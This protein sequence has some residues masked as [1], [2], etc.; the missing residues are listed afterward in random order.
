MKT[1]DTCVV[2]RQKLTLHQSASFVS[3]TGCIFTKKSPRAMNGTIQD[4]EL[5]GAMWCSAHSIKCNERDISR[6][7]SPAS[8]KHGSFHLSELKHTKKPKQEHHRQGSVIPLWDKHLWKGCF[9]KCCGER[10]FVKC[11]QHKTCVELSCQYQAFILRE[12]IWTESTCKI[13]SID[14]TCGWQLISWTGNVKCG[15]NACRSRCQVAPKPCVPIYW[16]VSNLKSQVQ[17]LIFSSVAPPISSWLCH[18]MT[19]TQ[20]LHVTY[21]LLPSPSISITGGAFSRSGRGIILPSFS[22]R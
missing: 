5:L 13:M 22:L 2:L 21:T 1:N 8:K 4:H 6:I 7:C 19:F 17:T 15:A 10:N 9:C 18:G 20:K 16:L 3:F 12:T 11:P 14:V